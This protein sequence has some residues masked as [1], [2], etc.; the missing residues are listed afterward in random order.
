MCALIKHTF[1]Q[2]ETIYYKNKTYSVLE[3][4]VPHGE[5]QNREGT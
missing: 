4:N 1:Q 2:G 3:S 5:K